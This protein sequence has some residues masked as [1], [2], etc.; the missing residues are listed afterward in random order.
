M[1]SMD[2]EL[3]RLVKEGQ[4]TQEMATLY[5]VHPETMERGGRIAPPSPGGGLG[6]GKRF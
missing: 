5:A 3:M 1:L 4:I 6:F 2:T